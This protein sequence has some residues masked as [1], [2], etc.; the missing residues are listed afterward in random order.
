MS[1]NTENTKQGC[2]FPGMYKAFQSAS[3]QRSDGC[4]TE[5]KETEEANPQENYS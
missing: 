2:E 5:E 4:I 3:T 1:K